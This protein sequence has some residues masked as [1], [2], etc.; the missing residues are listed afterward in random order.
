MVARQNTAADGSRCTNDAAQ[1]PTV[2]LHNG[3]ENEHAHRPG[4]M[5]GEAGA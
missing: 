2:Y 5:N 1:Q 4:W 3:T